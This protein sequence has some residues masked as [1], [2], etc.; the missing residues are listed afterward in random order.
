MR[1]T[2][3]SFGGELSTE[4]SESIFFFIFVAGGDV[5]NHQTIVKNLAA[6]QVTNFLDYGTHFPKIHLKN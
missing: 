1:E 2:E 3:R 5:R 4:L 6:K